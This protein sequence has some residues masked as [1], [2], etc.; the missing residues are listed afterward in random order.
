MNGRICYGFCIEGGGVD[1][2]QCIGLTSEP[3]V[4][5]RVP[6]CSNN[7]R[8]DVFFRTLCMPTV[9]RTSGSVLLCNHGDRGRQK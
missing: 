7:S 8:T 6:V 2:K 3:G 1:L 4:N 5:F 9:D